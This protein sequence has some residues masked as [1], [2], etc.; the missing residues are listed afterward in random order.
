[1]RTGE[2]AAAESNKPRTRT[3]SGGLL[4]PEDQPVNSEVHH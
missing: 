4:V 1:M 2:A 3:E